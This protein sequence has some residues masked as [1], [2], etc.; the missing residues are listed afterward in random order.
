ME[1]VHAWS[2]IFFKF[3]Y[4]VCFDVKANNWYINHDVLLLVAMV[5][6]L[7]DFGKKSDKK[8]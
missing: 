4:V 7:E 5:T 1:A 6:T 2:Q 3:S 8:S